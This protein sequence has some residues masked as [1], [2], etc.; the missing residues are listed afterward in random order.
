MN[1][2]KGLMMNMK[3][4]VKILGILILLGSG[5]AGC[6]SFGKTSPESRKSMIQ[7]VNPDPGATN[8]LD[9]KNIKLAKKVK[10]DIAALDEIYDVAVIVGKED[11]LVA[12]KVKH[13]KRFG[14][15]RIEKEI[16]KKLE[17]NYPD[18]D[19]IV[20]SDYKIFIEAVEL[21]ERMKNPSFPDK[22]AEEQLQRIISLKKELT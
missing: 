21:R 20:S 4:A 13:L 9:E 22:K 17:K 19:F 6:T 1:H 11:I 8:D 18:E 7:S 2:R 12:Y 15:K 5:I 16:N 14:M 3:H 10:K